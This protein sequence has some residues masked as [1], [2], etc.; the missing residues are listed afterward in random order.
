[1]HLGHSMLRLGEVKDEAE[2]GF[3]RA[4][5][6]SENSPLPEKPDYARADELLVEITFE[7]WR[8]NGELS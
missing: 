3:E 5:A 2:K 8:E 7:I 1:M 4:K 6:A